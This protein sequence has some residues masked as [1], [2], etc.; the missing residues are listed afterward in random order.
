MVKADAAAATTGPP[1]ALLIAALVAVPASAA[2][3]CLDTTAVELT[4]VEKIVVTRNVSATEPSVAVTVVGTIVTLV[5]M[6]PPLAEAMALIVAATTCSRTA[7]ITD[8]SS[9]TPDGSF[10]ENVCATCDEIT[11]L[12]VITTPTSGDEDKESD[13][14]ELN[15]EGGLEAASVYKSEELPEDLL[16]L[17]LRVVWMANL[18]SLEWCSASAS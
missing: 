4:V 6:T 16:F 11:S 10:N 18:S 9:P 12:N 14:D 5:G 15:E 17:L 7:A 2:Y 8:A 1:A 13:D 3:S